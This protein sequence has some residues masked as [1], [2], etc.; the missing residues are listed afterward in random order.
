MSEFCG[1]RFKADKQAKP[2]QAH[3]PSQAYGSVN[4]DVSLLVRH[5][6]ELVRADNGVQGAPAARPRRES[7]PRQSHR[8]HPS[9][10]HNSMTLPTYG[11]R[12]L[13]MGLFIPKAWRKNSCRRVL[14]CRVWVRVEEYIIPYYTYYTNNTYYT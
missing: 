14:I 2:S 3:K 1:S 4:G 8:T 10:T 12:Q 13:R 5:Y 9:P 11:L 7:K 6:K